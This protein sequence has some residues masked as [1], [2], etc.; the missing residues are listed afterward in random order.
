MTGYPTSEPRQAEAALPPLL[1]TR[2]VAVLAARTDPGYH[3]AVNVQGDTEGVTF[4]S[5]RNELELL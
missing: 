5:L 2:S 4:V 1:K 3:D